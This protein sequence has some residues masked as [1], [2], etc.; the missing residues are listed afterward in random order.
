MAASLVQQ[1]ADHRESVPAHQHPIVVKSEMPGHDIEELADVPGGGF[2]RL[3][4]IGDPTR[5]Q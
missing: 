5:V 3:L 1:A 4:E 2:K